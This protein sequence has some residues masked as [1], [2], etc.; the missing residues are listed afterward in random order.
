MFNRKR[1]VLLVPPSATPNVV[2]PLIMNDLFYTKAFFYG[3]KT[4]PTDGSA[5]T[6]NAASVFIGES[7]VDNGHIQC[8]DEVINDPSSPVIYQAV[9]GPLN[10]ADVYVRLVTPGDA[11]FVRLQ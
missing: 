7:D 2:V 9:D 1:R 6:P 3:L 11:L 5:A 4:V 10:M 8:V